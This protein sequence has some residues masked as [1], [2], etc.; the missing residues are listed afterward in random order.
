MEDQ[1]IKQFVMRELPVMMKQDPE[2]RQFILDLSRQHFAGKQETETRFDRLLDELRCD[3]EENSRKWQQ[4]QTQITR[5]LDAIEAL[6]RKHDSTIGALGARWGL[7]TEQSFRN[8]LAGIL[9]NS[10][11]VDVLNITEFDDTGEVFGRPDQVELDVIIQ[12]GT[13]ILCEIKA[14]MS[15]ADMY[16]FERKVRYYEKHHARKADRMLVISPMVETRAQQIAKT[17][18]IEVYSNADV[19][20]PI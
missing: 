9:E 8:A 15:K 17:L 3:R 1:Q 10:F 20:N 18:G 6:A 2:I 5:M 19:V 11:G 13:L 4:N 16:A 7:H 14:S 12:D